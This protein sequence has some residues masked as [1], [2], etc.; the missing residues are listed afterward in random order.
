[1]PDQVA[2][3][4]LWW[5]MG[6]DAPVRSTVVAADWTRL[7]AAYRTRASLH[8]VDDLQ[9]TDNND[10]GLAGGGD[11]WA[12]LDGLQDLDPVDAERIIGDRL[13]SQVAGIM[14]YVDHSAFTLSAPLIELGMDSLMAARIRHAAQA[15]F[16][17]ET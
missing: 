10:D 9:P 12:G 17:V 11:D 4:A 1:M 2:I 15:D 16:G 6:P 8:I 5:V 3:Q 13:C 14:G 7:A